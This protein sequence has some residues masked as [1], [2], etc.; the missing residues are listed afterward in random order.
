MLALPRCRIVRM[1]GGQ[2]W[3]M[4]LRDTAGR[5]ERSPSVDGGSTSAAGTVS[6]R[7]GVAEEREVDFEPAAVAGSRPDFAG[8]G[9]DGAALQTVRPMPAPEDAAC[10]GLRAR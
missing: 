10:G 5:R 9:L 8:E 3:A 7:I 2:G 1:R 6:S 4:L